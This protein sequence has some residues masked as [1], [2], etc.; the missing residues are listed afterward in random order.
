MVHKRSTCPIAN[1]LDEI[2]DKWTLLIIRD[3]FGGS[4]VLRNFCSLMNTFR[5]ISLLIG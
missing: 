4:S 2:G 1:M 5:P 3:M